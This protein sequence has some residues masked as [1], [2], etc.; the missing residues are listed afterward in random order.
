MRK[1]RLSEVRATKWWRRTRTGVYGTPESVHLTYCLSQV[2]A[3]R[4]I[5]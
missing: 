1:L 5:F 2:I 4:D 3:H